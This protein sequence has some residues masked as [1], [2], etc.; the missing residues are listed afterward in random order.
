[1]ID[2]PKRMKGLTTNVNSS[3]FRY[4]MMRAPAGSPRSERSTTA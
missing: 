3:D 4:T 2:M 1:M